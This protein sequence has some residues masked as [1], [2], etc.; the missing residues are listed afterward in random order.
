MRSPSDLTPADGPLVSVILPT[1]NRR[2]FLG[3]SIWSVLN[4]TYRNLEVIVVDDGSTD[5][6][7]ESVQSEFPEVRYLWQPNSGV[8]AARNRGLSAARGELIAFQDSDDLW[9]PNKLARQLALL[10]DRPEVG[11][12][13]TC[14]R[15][16]DQHGK[17][18]GRQWKRLHSGRVTEPLFQSI[19]VIMPSTVVRRS[20]VDCVGL[21]ST[22]L[23]T[24]SDYEFWLRASLVTEFAALEEPLVDVRRSPCRLTSAKG[25]GMTLQYQM[26]LR[27]YQDRGGSDAIR[28]EAARRAL[29]KSAFRA[30]RALKKESRLAAA[31]EMFARS[32]AHRFTIRSAGARLWTGCRRVFQ[33]SSDSRCSDTA[34]R[35]ALLPAQEPGGN[36][37]RPGTH[38]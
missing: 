10:T 3:E 23:R 30:G 25:E 19:F 13:Y 6:T 1:Y 21:F 34:C 8:A 28:P 5:A 32:L 36:L 20:V 16:V 12:V 17:P 29:A 9:H 14:H 35:L 27:F 33:S 15:I 2:Q 11:V 7:S 4:Q 38:G 31:Q 18:I 26:L 37:L 22:D 24:N